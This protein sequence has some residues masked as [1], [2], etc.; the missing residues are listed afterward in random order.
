MLPGRQLFAGG[1]SLVVIP[2]GTS[3]EEDA[4]E[5][6]AT[7]GGRSPGY[8]YSKVH[9]VVG[10]SYIG[11]VSRMTEER[12]AKRRQWWFCIAFPS[13]DIYSL[14]ETEEEQRRRWR[15]RLGW[16]PCS[17]DPP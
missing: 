12:R 10:W 6:D 8:L 17:D 11:N 15:G 16:V 5:L 2:R 4:A 14:T 1:L 9:A 7:E 3:G 13:C